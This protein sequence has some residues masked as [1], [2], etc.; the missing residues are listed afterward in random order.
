MSEIVFRRIFS[1][2]ASYPLLFQL[3][4]LAWRQRNVVKILHNFT[5]TVIRDRKEQLR[6][7]PI[8]VASML[9][10]HNDS[11]YD[12]KKLTFLD[13]LLTAT[14]DGQPLPNDGIREE[15][16]TFMFEVFMNIDII[17]DE[18]IICNYQFV[19]KRRVMTQQPPVYH[20]R[21]II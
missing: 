3:T 5:N 10:D 12:K 1:I 4:P 8:L 20:S 16:D 13:L 9:S 21:F 2:L 6:N 7:K 14:V 15:V 11:E 17:D 18:R 19:Q